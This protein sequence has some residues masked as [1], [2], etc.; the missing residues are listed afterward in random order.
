MTDIIYMLVVKKYKFSVYENTYM[1]LIYIIYTF[2][3]ITLLTK[4]PIS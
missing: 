3:S 2:Y 1:Q 4:K